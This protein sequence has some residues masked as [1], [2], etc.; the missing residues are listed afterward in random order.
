MPVEEKKEKVDPVY[1][2]AKYH[3]KSAPVLVHSAEEEK[4]LGDDWKD[5]PADHG[6]VTAPSDEQKG[7]KKL[8]EEH[9]KLLG[10]P[11]AVFSG[12]PALKSAKV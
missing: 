10:A 9:G 12:K 4:E 3:A 8:D 7:C 5:N 6:I 11:N 1:P 2:K